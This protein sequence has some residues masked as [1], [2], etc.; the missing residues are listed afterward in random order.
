MLFFYYVWLQHR[1]SYDGKREPQYTVFNKPIKYF[2]YENQLEKI[3][4]HILL[5]TYDFIDDDDA[6]FADCFCMF[7]FWINLFSGC[8][9]ND[10]RLRCFRILPFLF[11]SLWSRELCGKRYNVR[12]N[13]IQL[14]RSL[15]QCFIY[16]TGLIKIKPVLFIW[17][18][19]RRI[20]HPE[21]T[22]IYEH[23][24]KRF[25]L[26]SFFFIFISTKSDWK[27]KMEHVSRSWPRFAIQVELLHLLIVTWILNPCCV[28]RYF[29]GSVMLKF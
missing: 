25:I 5:K 29:R 15:K 2:Y 21:L 18:N 11:V 7:R 13:I 9:V 8:N 10:C 1:Q 6:L 19:K 27:F 14:W 24:Y 26:N 22:R 4:N 28:S 17:R 3:C 16:L 12:N 20:P 23:K